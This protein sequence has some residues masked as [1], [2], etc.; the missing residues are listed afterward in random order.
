MALSP[1]YIH[2]STFIIAEAQTTLATGVVNKYQ[3]VSAVAGSTIT[4]S[5]T[6]T[7]A[8]HSFAAGDRVLLVQMTGLT[9]ANGGKFE[10]VT[11]AAGTTASS[12]VTTTPIT[13]AYTP[14]TEKVQAIWVPYDATSITVPAGGISAL[15]WNGTTGGIV[16]ILTPGTLT[17]NGPIN[18]DGA[19]FRYADGTK[20]INGTDIYYGGGGGSGRL[21]AGGG[22]GGGGF[23][24]PGIGGNNDGFLNPLL[25]GTFN[26]GPPTP[27]ATLPGGGGG[28]AGVGAA[29]SG[30]AAGPHGGGGGGG[31]GYAGGGNG[32]KSSDSDAAGGFGSIG[33]NGD[34]D[35]AIALPYYNNSIGSRSV[36]TTGG[37]G[38]N[39]FIGGGGGA[40]SYGAEAYGADSGS[41]SSGKAGS[42]GG[43]GGLRGIVTTNPFSNSGNGGDG[44]GLIPASYNQYQY[45]DG[46][47]NC[48]DPRIWMAGGGQNTTQ[49]G[50]GVMVNASNIVANTKIISANGDA[51][52]TIID[53]GNPAGGGGGGG[54]LVINTQSITAGPLSLCAKG[55]QGAAGL[56]GDG[57]HGGGGGGSGGGGLVWVTDPLGGVG[58]NNATGTP[59]AIANMTFC[60]DGGASSV[61]ASN[62][63]SASF[64]G[65][66]GA[67]GNGAVL[68]N[69]PCGV[70]GAEACVVVPPCTKPKAAINSK[71][72]TICEGGTAKAMTATPS[73]V[74]TYA[75]YGP[76]ADTTSTLGTAIASATTATYTPTG[77]FAIGTKYY[78]V[79]TTDGACSDTAFAAVTVIAK[80]AVVKLCP[81]ET[82]TLTT[83]AGATAV[84]WYKDGVAVKD[85]TKNSFVVKA[86]G[87][88]SYSGIKP[89]SDMC[90]DSLCCP[91]VFEA[92]IVGSIGDYVFLDKD[93]SNTQTAGDT[94]VKD[95]KVY[96]LNSLGVKIDSTLTGADGKY[97]FSNLPLATYSVQFVAP[98]GQSFVTPLTGGDPAKD[99]DAGVGGKSAPVTLTAATPDVM[100]VDAGLKPVVVI[101]CGL[102]DCLNILIKKI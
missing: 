97:L 49:G 14:A 43:F 96:L 98:A 11:L 89:N 102:P 60:I 6:A 50:G 54:L 99:S 84:Q 25:T 100:T 9:S 27:K 101:P 78:A 57:L 37:G 4:L 15:K 23:G 66:G 63:K 3:P 18:A 74:V 61:A 73:T 45:C 1:S 21:F 75:W 41:I 44:G 2:H 93:N 26:G 79:I 62:P 87:S 94:P 33:S 77:S 53:A 13:R 35:G 64:T 88:Y 39:R 31:A 7:G 59:P 80:P 12:L 68:A 38:G 8:T 95:V 67:G 51:G 16:A 72:Q 22:G 69:N 5:G 70:F 85:S 58:R 86:I 36:R 30:G 83:D 42:N 32:G 34:T 24:N 81:N 46:S 92:C 76:L 29:G 19:G 17:L 71:T 56:S 91:V 55:G 40:A 65:T 28:G 48:P 10:F 47:F 52:V 82:Y 90:R 20:T